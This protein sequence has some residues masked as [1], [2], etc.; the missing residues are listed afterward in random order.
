MGIRKNLPINGNVW[1]IVNEDTTY[2]L[3]ARGDAGQISK[4]VNVTIGQTEPRRRA[5]RDR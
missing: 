4:S 1:V 2:T 5:A 3:T